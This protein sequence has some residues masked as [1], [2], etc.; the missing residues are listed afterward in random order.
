MF[1]IIIK[2]NSIQ[3]TKN[4]FIVIFLPFSNVDQI[5]FLSIAIRIPFSTLL[6][7]NMLVE[8]NYYSFFD[9]L[10]VQLQ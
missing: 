6:F 1:I 2:Y 5:P 7:G 3:R 4:V 8:A 10:S 9:F